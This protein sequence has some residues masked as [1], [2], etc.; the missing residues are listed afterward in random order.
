MILIKDKRDCCGCS[1][2]SQVCPQNCISIK[3]DNE[4]FLYPVVDDS[5]CT[6]CKLCEKVC[7]VISPFPPLNIHPKSYNSRVFDEDLRKKSSSGGLFTK[8]AS[9]IVENG[10]VVFGASFDSCWNVNH[11]WTDCVEG[12]A[13]IRGSKYVQSAIGNNFKV[14]KDFLNAGRLV[15][16]T[17]T[18]CQ[19]AGLKHYLRK[20]YDNLYTLD[21]VCHSAPSPLIWKMYLK[22]V[23]KERYSN[24]QTITFRSKDSGWREYGLK[25]ISNNEIIVEGTKSENTYMKGFLCDLYTR[26]SCSKCPAR[27]YTSGSDIMLGDSWGLNIYHPEWDDN[28]GMSLVLVKTSKGEFLINSIT[29]GLF[30]EPIP[31][32]EVEEKGLH[33]PIMLSSKP[34]I[35]RDYFYK[36]IHDGNIIDLIEKC[37]FYG[38]KYYRTAIFIKKAIKKVLPF[39]FKK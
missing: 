24:I 39:F 29:K 5:K 23:S 16:F 14:A 3:A 37:L 27:N 10:G 31:Y 1:A 17:G 12:L 32:F 19:I 38:E 33:A 8:I 20:D 35:L 13:D 26:P 4:G 11:S 9:Y 34:H 15:L 2:C 18:P 21:V 25:I 36:R 30:F 22:E 6:N 7:P 28:K